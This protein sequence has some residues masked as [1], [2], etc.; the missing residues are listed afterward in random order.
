VV[1][2]TLEGFN[3]IPK[4]KSIIGNTHPG[5]IEDKHALR[6]L[7]GVDRLDNAFYVSETS[8]EALADKQMLF[9]DDEDQ[10]DND[11][12][13]EIVNSLEN[14]DQDAS[15]PLKMYLQDKEKLA[16]VLIS[17]T[18]VINNDFVFI[19]DEFYRAKFR[20]CAMKKKTL[21]K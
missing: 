15:D 9:E 6:G 13:W 14:E 2:F 3:A 7:Y 8:T 17:P 12:T 19:L 1:Q 18:L 20:V 11:Q 16:L 5:R 21:Q 10:V 4:L